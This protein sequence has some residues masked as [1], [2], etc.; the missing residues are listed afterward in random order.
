MNKKQ[1]V[2]IWIM[3]F[4]IGAFS[5]HTA[6]LINS[7]TPDSLIN[8]GLVD[9]GLKAHKGSMSADQFNQLCQECKVDPSAKKRNNEDAM[10]KFLI[11]M[12]ATLSIGGLLLYTLKS[13]NK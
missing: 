9:I 2:A 8:A 4:F 1:L 12:L 3:V 13:K 10:L 11:E 5:F 6:C 7:I